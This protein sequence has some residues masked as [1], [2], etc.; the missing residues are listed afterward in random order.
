MKNFNPCPFCGNTDI[1]VGTVARAHNLPEDDSWNVTHY[2]AVCNARTTGCG[3]S[4][5]WDCET[6]EEAIDRWNKRAVISDA[7]DYKQRLVKEYKEVE[8]R[9]NELR[10]YL[11]ILGIEHA[12]IM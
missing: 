9:Y 7:A 6:Y 11:D 10:R 8:N 12:D 3:A 1:F 4:V 2:T 5:G